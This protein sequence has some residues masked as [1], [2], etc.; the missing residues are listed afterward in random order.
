MY[1]TLDNNYIVDE[2][3]Y[4]MLCVYFQKYQAYRFTYWKH[5]L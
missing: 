3:I 2:K 5:I 1:F 4:I